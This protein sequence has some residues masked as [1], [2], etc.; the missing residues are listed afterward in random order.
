MIWDLGKYKN[1]IALIS[2]NE[3]IDYGSL[4]ACSEKIC[5]NIRERVLVFLL[6]SNTYE[7]VAGYIGFLNHGIVPVMIDSSLDMELL[8]KLLDI[9][10]PKYIWMPVNMSGKFSNYERSGSLGSYVL[11]KTGERL[12]F[13]L[14]DELALLM[15]TSGSTGS[16]KLVRLS[17]KNIKANTESIIKYLKIDRNER[18][19]TNLPMHYVYG[20]SIINTHLYAGASVVMTEKS[21]FQKEFWQIVREQEVTN[22]GGVPYTFEMLNRLRFF[23]MDLP[24]LKTITQ[25]GGKLSPALHRKFAEYASQ[26]GKKFVVMYGA[27]EATARMGYLPPEESLRKCGAMGI[28]IPGGRFSL[29]DEEGRD[30]EVPHTMGELIY[31]GDN[32]MLGYAERGEDLAKG[33]EEQGSLHT[34][35]LAEFDEDGYYTILGRKKRFLKIYGK[36]I[37]LQEVEFILQ[38][39]FNTL[40]IA[41]S[42]RDD[43][44]NV[45]LEGDIPAEEVKGYIADKFKIHHLALKICCVDSI[46]KNSSGKV[47]YSKLE[48]MLQ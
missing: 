16:P 43:Q 37:N 4:K 15:T 30:I 17:Y 3:C 31:H 35:D 8:S 41:V 1:N 42:G 33:D 44:M 14:Y 18:S 24:A 2:E 38:K 48:A 12:S 6:C 22:F 26:K 25:A 11:L 7:S 45:F 9:Y 19:I 46:P 23:K 34:G 5:Q 21:M 29:V 40:G 39:R 32:V 13:P 28:P 10:R 36:R 47:L 27:A 20:L